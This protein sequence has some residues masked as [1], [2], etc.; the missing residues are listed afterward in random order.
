[1]NY[2][3]EMFNTVNPFTGEVLQSWNYH[4]RNQAEEKI[5]QAYRLQLRWSRD[6]KARSVYL[7]NLAGQLRMAARQ[8]AAQMALEMGK[9]LKD[10][11]AE[12]EKSASACVWWAENGSELLRAESLKAQYV[13]TRVLN[14][15]LG[16]VL[17]IMPW[18]YPLW[19][20]I[21]FAAPAWM[22]GNVV[23]LKHSDLTAGTAELIGRICSTEL[24]TEDSPIF[25]LRISHAMTAE[26]IA[27]PRVRAVTFTGSTRGGSAVAAL[28][29]QHLKKAVMELGGNDAYVVLSDADLNLAV[30][31]CVT[32]KLIN[33]GQSCIAAKR[34]FIA[35]KLKDDFLHKMSAAMSSRQSGDPLLLETEL[36]PLAA[37][38]FQ[39]QL[40]EQC[41][42]LQSSAKTEVILQ[43]PKSTDTAASFSPRVYFQAEPSSYFQK[44]EFFGPVALVSCFD[45]EAQIADLVNASPY[46]LGAALFS[47]DIEK[48][49]ALTSSWEVGMVCI[50][51]FVRSDSRAPFGGVKASGF[52]RELGRQGIL[53]F[54]NIQTVGVG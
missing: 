34:F 19:Q 22:A 35:R 4:T 28:A 29:G 31:T 24:A 37:K 38:R 32:A 8:I 54:C 53:E 44:E 27:D 40:N 46:G 17:A 47:Q 7:K 52:G 18:N 5:T 6:T 48:A 42:Q 13:E 25:N 33:N 30:E 12:V 16:V 36:G 14:R 43:L 50:N 9:P 51:D 49:K 26:L 3:L 2:S 39:I 23:L 10:G 1:M 45:S 21:R 20:L 11:L 41:L 15:S